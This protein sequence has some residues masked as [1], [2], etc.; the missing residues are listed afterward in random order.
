ML[1]RCLAAT[2]CVNETCAVTDRRRALP[3]TEQQQQQSDSMS[4]NQHQVLLAGE[5]AQRRPLPHKSPLAAFTSQLE[6]QQQLPPA[7]DLVRVQY[8]QQEQEPE[9]PEKQQP[10]WP[11]QE[12]VDAQ[13]LLEVEPTAVKI[14][15]EIGKGAFSIVYAGDYRGQHVAVKCQPKDAEGNIPAFVLREVQVLRLLRHPRLLQFAG[16]ADNARAKQVWILSEYLNNGDVDL[17]LKAIRSEKKPHIG[18]HRVVRIALDAAQGIEFLQQRHIVHR[19]IK[20][21]NI[22]LDDQHRAKLCDFGFAVEVKPV[23]AMAHGVAELDASKQ[24]RKSYCGTDAYMAPEMFLDEDYDHSVDIFS[25]GVVLMEMLC[26]RVANSDG[27]LMRLPQYKFQVLLPEFRD[28]LPASCPSA[29]A[30]LAE[31][32]VS[33]EPSERPDIKTIVRTLEDVLK[34]TTSSRC[35]VVELIPFT[36]DE[37][38]PQ[39]EADD[40]AYYGENDEEDGDDDDDDEEEGEEGE[41]DNSYNLQ[42]NGRHNTMGMESDEEERDVRSQVVDDP[43]LDEESV[44]SDVLAQPASPAPYHEGVILKR[45]RRGKRS[46]VEKWF[47]VDHDQLHYTDVPPGWRQHQQQNAE[48]RCTLPHISSLSLRECRIWKTMEMPELRFNV[49]DDNW[50]IK[51]E[52]QAV[53]KRDLDLWMELINQGI[54]YANELYAR[55]HDLPNNSTTGTSAS[56]SNASRPSR[57]KAKKESHSQC[58]ASSKPQERRSKSNSDATVPRKTR[59]RSSVTKFEEPPELPETEEDRADEVY[60][61]LK[62]IGYQRYAPMLKVKGFDSLDFIRETGIEMEDLNFVGIKEPVARK[63]IRSAARTLRGDDDD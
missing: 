20:S 18:W 38:E 28:A 43:F 29:L 45:G 27:F 16:A 1:T 35:D 63:A 54:D 37:R 53:S 61:W 59:R 9:Q 11:E 42:A 47:I 60:Q 50:K 30:T 34:H 3:S 33:F 13:M 22:L 4:G 25:F 8:A 23:E 48:W 32:C 62:Q 41:E 46:W 52:L 7:K 55:E 51:R 12:G 40:D 14:G 44:D 39:I 17:L 49:I 10:E 6:A 21:S 15:R 24:R 57:N 31:K 56:S 58:Q 2:F 36:P 5:Y 19:D 26:C